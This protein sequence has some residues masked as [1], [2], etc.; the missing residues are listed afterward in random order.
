MKGGGVSLTQFHES[1]PRAPV[2]APV[3]TASR[4]QTV[5]VGGGAPLSVMKTVAVLGVPGPYPP[6][7]GCCGAALSV[8]VR[9]PPD[10]LSSTGLTVRVANVAP[11]GMVTDPDKVS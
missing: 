9:V 8:T 1:P 2:H 6:S 7:Y 5:S 4:T 3:R 11:S 10:L